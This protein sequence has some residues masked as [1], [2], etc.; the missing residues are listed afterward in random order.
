MGN[1][2]IYG[3][4]QIDVG[5]YGRNFNYDCANTIFDYKS[6]EHFF[7]TRDHN[8]KGEKLI[9]Q[10]IGKGKFILSGSDTLLSFEKDSISK[11][12]IFIKYSST[13]CDH[14]QAYEHL[15]NS[16]FIA[17]K[18]FLLA[19]TGRS[20]HIIFTKC[21]NVEG[22]VYIDHFISEYKS[23]RPV[24]GGYTSGSDRMKFVSSGGDSEYFWNLDRDSLILERK[25]YSHYG[26]PQESFTLERF[27]LV[28]SR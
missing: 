2:Q 10:F 3:K 7:F 4:A 14:G 1:L 23:Y 20:H 28:K 17:G 8:T 6:N 21:G 19:D 24:L 25:I 18:Y 9:K 15:V 12:K 27:V 13:S 26:D 22:A 16:K 11:P 5:G